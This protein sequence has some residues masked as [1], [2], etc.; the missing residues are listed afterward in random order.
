MLPAPL[1]AQVLDMPL[2]R[3]VAL[4]ACQMQRA[5]KNPAG[6]VATSLRDGWEPTPAELAKANKIIEWGSVLFDEGAEPAEWC[7]VYQYVTGYTIAPASVNAMRDGMRREWEEF[8]R[9]LE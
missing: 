3:S 1:V 4:V 6:Y 5:E 9:S 8:V 2:E 7:R